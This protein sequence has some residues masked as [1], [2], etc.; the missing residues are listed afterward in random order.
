MSYIKGM[1]KL[2][3]LS[4]EDFYSFLTACPDSNKYWIACSGGMDSCVLLHLFYL[5]KDRIK[6]D[7][8]VIYVN[9]KLQ[10]K[11]DEWEVFCEHLCQSYGLK[12]SGLKLTALRPKEKSVEEWAR[13]QR[14]NLI[15]E[16]IGND[17][18]LFTAHHQDDQIE[19]FFLHVLR[20]SG[21]R[22][23]VSMPVIREFSK[24]Y[25][26]RPL[27]DITRCELHDY[28][29]QHKLEWHNDPSNQD[30]RFNRNFLRNEILPLIQGRWPSYRKSVNRLIRHQQ[31]VKLL[32]DEIAEEDFKKTYIQTTRGIDLNQISSLSDSRKKNLISFWLKKLDF[33]LPGSKHLEQILTDIFTASEDSNPCVN[34]DGVQI[35]RYRNVMYAIEPMSEHNFSEKYQ[36]DL[37]K[38]LQVLDDSLIASPVRGK[39]LTK[40]CIKDDIVEIRYRQGGEKIHPQ[41]QNISK[42]VKQLFQEK[43]V[44]PWYRDRIPLVYIEGQLALIPGLCIDEKFCAKNNEVAWNIEWTGYNKAISC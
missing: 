4:K 9:H 36:W 6:Q 7:I 42:T 14:Y 24:G 8:E 41:N 38:S 25:L 33:N 18:I 19:T 29:K 1:T 13:E 11:N 5:N 26:V 20:G 44:L 15:A 39:G 2:N 30:S 22:G 23:L 16:C 27:L 17:D 28:A 43:G 3:V 37:K 34:W 35:R 10:K 32:L 40:K 21:P 31:E 12:F